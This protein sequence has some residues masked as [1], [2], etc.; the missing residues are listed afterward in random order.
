MMLKVDQLCKSFGGVH[1]VDNLSFEV[2]E[3]EILGL[4]GP[5]GAGKTTVL[6]V[7]SGFHQ[8]SSGTVLFQDKNI[9]NLKPH[10]IAKLGIGRNFQSSVLFMELPVIENVFTAYHMAY[11]TGVWRNLLYLPSARREERD[12]RRSADETLEK[13]GLGSLKFEVTKNLPHG[14]QRVLGVCLALATRP[15]LLLLDEPL[16][17]MNK[18]EVQTMSG[19]IKEIRDDGVTIAMIEHNMDAVM[20]ICDRIVVMASGT[21]IAEGLPKEIQTNQQV[22]EAY[23]GKE[24]D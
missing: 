21:K 1:A 4:I 22:I 11:R 20:S 3:R 15:K 14:Y 24:D 2:R 13:M 17:G 19:L 9:S 6:N 5:N 10:E 7:I 12:L 8:A 18:T 23:L 16:T